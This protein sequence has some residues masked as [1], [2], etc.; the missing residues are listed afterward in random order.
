MPATISSPDKSPTSP[1]SPGKSKSGKALPADLLPSKQKSA[2]GKIEQSLE[3]PPSPAQFNSHRHLLKIAKK[4]TEPIS[5]Q[6]LNPI[7]G[8]EEVISI[9]ERPTESPKPAFLR[10]L[11]SPLTNHGKL[12]QH[13]ARLNKMIRRAIRGVPHMKL[14]NYHEIKRSFVSALDLLESSTTTA[15]AKKEP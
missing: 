15:L 6:K 2:I 10:R 3:A 4:Q 8:P 1:H 14:E 12:L 13:K 7:P 5:P 11:D 9:T